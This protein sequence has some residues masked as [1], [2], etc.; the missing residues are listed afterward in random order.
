M[1]VGQSG[2]SG[3]SCRLILDDDSCIV[4]GTFQEVYGGSYSSSSS[5]EYEVT[6]GTYDMIGGGIEFTK[7]YFPFN[8]QYKAMGQITV[9]ESD[10]VDEKGETEKQI[11]FLGRWQRVP[12]IRGG[13]LDMR[14]TN[15]T[16]LEHAIK[17]GKYT[18][19]GLSSWRKKGGLRPNV[20]TKV[21][22]FGE[23]GVPK[24]HKVT[25][26]LTNMHMSTVRYFQQT[27]PGA[28]YNLS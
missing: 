24:T 9:E 19:F 23:N 5:F 12:P 27:T 8:Y 18:F 20:H 11:K 3:C 28:S 10:E 14:L 1:T 7:W 13:R 4:G 17:P 22:F 15:Q 21:L 25:N 2:G 6:N 16:V 26:H